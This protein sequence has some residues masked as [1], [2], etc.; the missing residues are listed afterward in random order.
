MALLRRRR[1][2]GTDADIDVEYGPSLAKGPALLVGSIL[3]AFGLTG[4]LTNADFPPASSSFPDGTS[5]GS[6]WLGFEVNG[7][8]N[9]FCIAAG[10]LLMFAAAQHHLAKM[11]SLLVGLALGVCALI[12]VLDGNDVFGLAAAN[13][14]TKLGFAVASGVLLFNALMPRVKRRHVRDSADTDAAP[15]HA[16][17]DTALPAERTGERHARFRRR[18]RDR[19]GAEA[20][21]DRLAAE[22]RAGSVP[23]SER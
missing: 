16:T 9:F 20:E 14:L 12:A 22:Q 17:Q 3:V 15:A 8:T 18:D 1:A 4:L 23:A 10:A 11:M 6:S 19:T 5:N 13:S 7:W 21:Q 2:A